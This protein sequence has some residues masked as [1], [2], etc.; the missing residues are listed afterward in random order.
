M[1][2]GRC[3]VTAK[4]AMLLCKVITLNNVGQYMYIF[5]CILV[6]HIYEFVFW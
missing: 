3:M 2:F 6:D 5:L 1:N 4:T